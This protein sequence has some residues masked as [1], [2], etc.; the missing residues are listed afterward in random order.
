[1]TIAD[2]PR[3]LVLQGQKKIVRDSKPTNSVDANILPY[4]K[5]AVGLN[6]SYVAEYIDWFEVADDYSGDLFWC[7]PSIKAMGAYINTD[8]NFNYW[9]APAGFSRGMI[10]ASDVAFSPNPK[11]AGAIY[12]KSLNY[13]ISYAD[14]GIVLEGQKTT[15]A[16]PSA[17]DRVNVRRLFLR[18]ERMSYYTARYFVY[19]GNTAYT[20]Q[21]LV[22]ALDPYFKEA[23]VGGGIYDYRIL[24]DETIN[25][26]DVIDRNELHVKIAI[27]P[28][29]TIEFIMLDFI[30]TR[31]GGS[32][33]EVL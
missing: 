28:T 11:Q 16:V 21:R 9:D 32:F 30:A 12:E 2:G 20:R 14:E 17:F 4:L 5:A 25:G 7:P 33:E 23:K 31:T 18:L 1:M 24:C 8:A 27:K 15:Q 19:E 10:A 6:S 22:D 3:S 26:P 29:K 13:A